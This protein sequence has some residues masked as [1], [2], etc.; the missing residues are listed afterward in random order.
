MLRKPFYLPSQYSRNRFHLTSLSTKQQGEEVIKFHIIFPAAWS[1]IPPRK[2]G[3]K[4]LFYVL[5]NISPS[6][7]YWRILVLRL[8]VLA[9]I[10][11]FDVVCMRVCILCFIHNPLDLLSLFQESPEFLVF[12]SD[13]E[14]LLS[15]DLE[16]KHF[17]TNQRTFYTIICIYW[18]INI[19]A[20][21]RNE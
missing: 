13:S 2:T 17:H 3:R 6:I 8:G 12:G 20:E 10:Y 7:R 4:T 1:H 21:K 16:E 14:L 19:L 9:V 11:G 5:E 18:N 15:Q